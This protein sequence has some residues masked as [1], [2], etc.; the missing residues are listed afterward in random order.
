MKKY[1]LLDTVQF[2]M[3]PYDIRLDGIALITAIAYHYTPGNL[4]MTLTFNKEAPS[5]IRGDQLASAV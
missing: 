3:M 5:G 2:N 1:K 4:R